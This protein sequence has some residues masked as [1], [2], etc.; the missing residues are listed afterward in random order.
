[1]PPFAKQKPRTHDDSLNLV[2]AACWRKNKSVRTVSDSHA[3]LLRKYVFEDYST[4]N[5]FHP[6][7]ICDGC[8]YT[9]TKLEKVGYLFTL[10]WFVLCVTFLVHSKIFFSKLYSIFSSRME[11]RPQGIC[12]QHP[13]MKVW[14]LQL[15]TQDHI[16][17]LSAAARFVKLH[18]W[19]V[20][21][22]R[23]M[24]PHIPIKLEPQKWKMFPPLQ[25]LFLFAPSALLCSV[26]VF[27]TIVL[28]YKS[29]KILL[30]LWG[31]AQERVKARW[32]ATY[33]KEFAPI[34]VF[35]SEGVP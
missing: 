14:L 33:W 16:L 28:K 2:C 25:E 22:T 24:Q 18:K 30:I 29:K 9:I 17:V 8:R 1:M 13:H 31:L 34:L 32:Q 35:P 26:K 5:S 6:K 12:P 23:N 27:P 20:Q 21:L 7:V 15:P 19:W 11:R 10:L 3:D 4:K